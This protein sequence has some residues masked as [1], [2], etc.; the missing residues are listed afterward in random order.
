MYARFSTEKQSRA[1]VEDQFRICERAAERE[2]LTVVSRFSDSAI[3]GSRSDRPGYQQLSAAAARREFEVLLVDDLSRLSR[4]QV[5]SER[6][7]R[8]LEFSGTRILAV[9][10][11]Y[12]SRNKARK[13]QRGVKGLMNEMYLDDLKA[14]THRG[15]EG[16]ALRGFWAGGKPYGYKLVRVKDPVRRD[17]YGEPLVI[18]TNLQIDPDTSAVVIEIF[19]RYA[20][21]WSPRAI[22]DELNMRRIASPGS[23]WHNRKVRRVAGWQGSCI[24]SMLA[25]ELYRGECV[26]NHTQWTKDPDTGQRRVIERPQSEWVKASR[27]ELR[28]VSEMLWQGV[29]ARHRQAAALG[30]NVREVIKRSGHRAGR[31]PAYLFSSLLKCGLCGVPMVIAGGQGKYKSYGCSTRREGGRHACGNCL[32]I[33]LTT[34]ERCLLAPSGVIC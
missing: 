15:Q 2:G 14:K 5:E 13:I 6:L 27:P 24:K 21:G 28:I 10:D 23:A 3:S 18:G 17:A 20:D 31:G 16:K 32:I 12:D 25:N 33:K 19:R 34:A 9:S 11:G 8:R 1:S 22:A 29:E 26:W 4:D 30:A 7:I